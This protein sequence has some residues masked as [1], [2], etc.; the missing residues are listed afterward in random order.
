MTDMSHVTEALAKGH[1]ALTGSMGPHSGE[2][3]RTEQK[4]ESS[5]VGSS[6]FFRATAGLVAVRT[7]LRDQPLRLTQ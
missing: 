6:L 7:I 4:P 5:V 3:A 2:L 1:P